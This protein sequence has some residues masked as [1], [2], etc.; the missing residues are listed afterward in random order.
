[1]NVTLDGT[2]PMPSRVTFTVVV[3]VTVVIGAAPS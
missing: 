1:V 3:L 2:A